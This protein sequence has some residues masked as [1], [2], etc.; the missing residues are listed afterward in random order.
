MQ[1]SSLSSSQGTVVKVVYYSTWLYFNPD[2]CNYSS[3]GDGVGAGSKNALKLPNRSS[4]NTWHTGSTAYGIVM[5]CLA[6][7]TP[8]NG[9]P[10]LYKDSIGT[11]CTFD[12]IKSYLTLHISFMT[13]MQY[14]THFYL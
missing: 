6:D 10:F 14:S 3:I 13:T 1:T 2:Q 4:L 11:V 5:L 12:L 8:G 7:V 9:G